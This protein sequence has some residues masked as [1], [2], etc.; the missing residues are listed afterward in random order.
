MEQRKEAQ[1]HNRRRLLFHVFI[2]P[3]LMDR[4]RNSNSKKKTAC[5][6][7][8]VG[9]KGTSEP[10]A[11]ISS[12]PRRHVGQTNLMK[13]SQPRT[14]FNGSPHR[15]MLGNVMQDAESVRKQCDAVYYPMSSAGHN[16]CHTQNNQLFTDQQ[17][18]AV[19]SD[20][21]SSRVRRIQPLQQSVWLDAQRWWCW[22]WCRVYSIMHPD[23]REHYTVLGLTSI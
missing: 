12:Y 9:T 17:H 3:L 22:C 5:T 19:Q 15:L 8:D 20:T 21:Q 2:L 11:K 10:V 13:E 4:N 1:V 18:R 7:N 14:A 6:Q 16:L 23:L